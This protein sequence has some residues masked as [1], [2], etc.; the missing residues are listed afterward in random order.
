MPSF[1]LGS[2]RMVQAMLFGHLG[3][4][5][6]WLTQNVG[7]KQEKLVE[8]VDHTW[9]ELAADAPSRSARNAVKQLRSWSDDVKA[10]LRTRLDRGG[11]LKF[12]ERQRA[13]A[14]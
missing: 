3:E 11:T 9:T 13:H 5:M 2:R 4:V 14:M 12:V 1:E 10:T 8:I 7:A 6:W